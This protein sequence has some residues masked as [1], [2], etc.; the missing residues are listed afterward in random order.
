MVNVGKYSIHE[1]YGIIPKPECFGHFFWWI[2]L[3]LKKTP[4]IR[5]D[6][7]TGGLVAITLLL[8]PQQ[9]KKTKVFHCTF[10]GVLSKI[11]AFDKE[12]CTWYEIFEI[13]TLDNS[14]CYLCVLCLILAFIYIYIYMCVY[15]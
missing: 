10:F 5:G 11:R 15:T 1:A 14:I 2:F 9:K 8:F 4:W 12:I 6:N 13:Q 7:F 3:I